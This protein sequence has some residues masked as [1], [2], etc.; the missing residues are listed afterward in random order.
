MKNN[1]TKNLLVSFDEIEYRRDLH[2]LE[3]LIEKHGKKLQNAF[4]LTGLGKLNNDYLDAI[5]RKNLQIIRKDIEVVISDVLDPRYLQR[6]ITGNVNAK[7]QELEK[8]TSNLQETI[9]MRGLYHL[10][11]YISV[12]EN[13]IITLSDSDK[14]RLKEIHSQYISTDEGKKRYQLHLNAV[15]AINA[16]VTAMGEHL[17]YDSPLDSF[18]V[19]DSNKV[20][21][22]VYDYE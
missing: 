12:D 4:E 11:E 3:S 16:F 15:K 8:E 7:M 19:G 13:G 2:L 14:K 17:G 22:K 10:T 1:E 21:P 5:L 9:D 20:I 18:G 6:E